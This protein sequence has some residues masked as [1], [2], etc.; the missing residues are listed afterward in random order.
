MH[1]TYRDKIET[2]K[3]PSI[4]EMLESSV[5][6]IKKLKDSN[7][8]KLALLSNTTQAIIPLTNK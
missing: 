6:N 5:K 2:F 3:N 1:K 4:G 7:P 8:E